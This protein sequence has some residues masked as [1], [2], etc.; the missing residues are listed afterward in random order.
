MSRITQH[1]T[2]ET[3]VRLVKAARSL[4]MVIRNQQVVGS[5]ASS[6]TEHVLL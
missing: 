1:D 5:A 3:I 2:L 4:R 6:S